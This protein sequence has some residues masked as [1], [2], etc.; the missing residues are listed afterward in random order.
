MSERI[1]MT[2]G[3]FEKLEAELVRL[4]TVDRPHNVQEIAEARAHGDIS[5]NAEFHA[6]KERQSHL[7]A[8]ILQ[9]EDRIAR[10]QIIEPG[11]NPPDAVRFGTTV[12]LED[13]DSGEEVSYTLVGE[14]ESD[15]ASG[16]IS[17][18]SPVARAL[19]GKAPGDEVK[20]RVPK[21]TRMFEVLSVRYE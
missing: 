16:L 5:E 9:V 2:R 13:T 14:D 3:G 17:V 11:V 8:R 12:V 18:A 10:A 19:L 6:A 21:G 1:P 7:E 20:V 4:K 15:V